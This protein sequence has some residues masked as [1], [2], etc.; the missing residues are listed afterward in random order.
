MIQHSFLFLA[1]QCAGQVEKFD[2]A[3]LIVI[4][5]SRFGYFFFCARY[6][7]SE[8]CFQILNHLIRSTQNASLDS[9]QS[10]IG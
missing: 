1:F 5:K 9:T 6:Q 2:K 7:F 10:W 8:Q 3:F 4:R